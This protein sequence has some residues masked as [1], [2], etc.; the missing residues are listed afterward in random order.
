MSH[1][2]ITDATG[3][4]VYFRPTIVNAHQPTQAV[5]METE[6]GRPVYF[7]VDQLE[8]VIAGMRDV[9]RQAAGQPAAAA[10]SCTCIHPPEEDAGQ[11]LHASYCTAAV[12]ETHIVADDSD[13]P[14]HVDDCPGCEPA[15]GQPDTQQ[16]EPRA[17][18]EAAADRLALELTADGPSLPGYPLAVKTAVRA[19]R[20][21]ADEA[22]Q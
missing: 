19:L 6:T 22:A 2:E 9:R 17:V 5:A 7:A 12:E 13:D 14:E 15:A 21:M 18:L 1:F 10:P 4:R 11:L 8:D 16:P 20:R 3:E